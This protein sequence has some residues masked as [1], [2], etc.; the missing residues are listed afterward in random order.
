MENTFQGHINP[1]FL[2]EYMDVECL[3]QFVNKEIFRFEEEEEED[4]EK[5]SPSL[6]NKIPFLQMLQS[7]DSTP[8]SSF[9]QQ[10]QQPSFHS[11][12]K[13]QQNLKKTQIWDNRIYNMPS[14]ESTHIQ[15]NHHQQQQQHQLESCITHEISELNSPEKS[16][17]KGHF[18]HHH[19]HHQ[20]YTGPPPPLSCF[21]RVNSVEWECN[22]E[23]QTNPVE[24]EQQLS[25]RVQA[26]FN[27]SPPPPVSR[28][29]RKRKRAKV[30]K[31]KEEVENQRMTHIAVERNRRRQ[32]ND[33]L[34]SL[35]SLMPPSYV[36]RGDQASIIGGAIDFVKELEQ[37]LQSLQAQKRLR[38]SDEEN[39]GADS[40]SPS[41]S[42]E[43]VAG[44][45]A[46]NGFLSEVGLSSS[47]AAA[48]ANGM[49]TTS[50]QEDGYCTDGGGG[51]NGEYR[52]EK[53]TE[54]ADIEVT[55]IH[56]HVN[57]KIQCRRRPGQLLKAIV[58]LED[59]RL[60]VLHL[61]ITSS[62]QASILYSFNLRIEDGCT[63]GSAEEIVGAVHQ[64]FNFINS[65]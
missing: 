48:A 23:Q 12:L 40:T 24:T 59:L 2:E 29:R 32:M 27:K 45:S 1:S 11:L 28:E 46:F 61:N 65:S 44:L 5:A 7:V 57:L 15:T 31:N 22:Q 41:S 38:K 4:D 36:Q 34:N 62:L 21:E 37:L 63:V 10:Q 16:E 13:L 19:L 56:S 53:K 50:N 3:E 18:F 52:A 64:I 42:A 49:G 9:T 60:S 58:A 43:E 26:H 17:T 55:V 54:A 8:F 47:P 39:G 6:E 14:M 35:R 51:R 25:Y 30:S 33:H 20:Q